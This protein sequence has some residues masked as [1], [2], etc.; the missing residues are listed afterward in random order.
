MR[1]ESICQLSAAAH[2]RGKEAARIGG[3]PSDAPPTDGI[4]LDR[5]P[6]DGASLG[7]EVMGHRRWGACHREGVPRRE[8]H[9][10][11]NPAG[12]CVSDVG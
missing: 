7:R 2:H 12:E 1:K 10:R 8:S 4:A 9:L 3:A 5:E 6:L 11:E